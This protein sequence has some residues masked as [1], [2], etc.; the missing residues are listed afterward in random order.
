MNGVV[1]FGRFN[2]VGLLG[3]ALQLALFDLMLN[4]WHIQGES[5]S[6]IAVEIAVLHNFLWHERFTWRD[7]NRP[8]IR[9]RAMRLCRF[10]M[11]NGLLSLVGNT[12]LTYY[13]VQRLHLPGVPS[14]AAAVAVCAPLNFLLANRWVYRILKPERSMRPSVPSLRDSA[15]RKSACVT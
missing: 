8:G 10:H 1:R 13:L 4:R 15:A 6:A 5:A 11:S 3:A 9:E 2:L 14:A 7:R 12:A